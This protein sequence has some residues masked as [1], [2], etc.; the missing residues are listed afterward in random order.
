MLVTKTDAEVIGGGKV[1]VDLI[2]IPA[3]AGGI[4]TSDEGINIGRVSQL[5]IRSSV[6]S[7]VSNTDGKEIKSLPP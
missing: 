7:F 2:G 6:Q 3:F 1:Q 4:K 5:E